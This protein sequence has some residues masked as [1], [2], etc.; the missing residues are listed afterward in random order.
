MIERQ[1]RV[2]KRELRH[3]DF[4]GEW[5]YTLV[6]ANGDARNLLIGLH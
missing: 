4:H 5:N 6:P 1:P 2:G 3:H